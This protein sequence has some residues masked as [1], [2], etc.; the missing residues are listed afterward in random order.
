MMSEII[1]DEDGLASWSC[2]CGGKVVTVAG[3]S[4]DGVEF[5]KG[6]RCEKCGA[7]SSAVMGEAY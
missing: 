2:T 3:M 6:R 5:E 7:I 1:I 4:T